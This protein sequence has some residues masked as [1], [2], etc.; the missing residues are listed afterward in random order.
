MTQAEQAMLTAASG[1]TGKLQERLND[2]IAT[3][4]STMIGAG[5]PV[6]TSPSVPD[7]FRND[8]MAYAVYE[9][10]LDFPLN[11]QIS[12]LFLTDAR[13]DAYKAAKDI[14]DKIA[15]LKAGAIEAPTGYATTGNW[16]SENRIIMRTHPI[17]PPQ[18]QFTNVFNNQP[19]YANPN[20]TSITPADTIPDVPKNCTATPGNTAGTITVTF[21]LPM[22]SIT[23][24]VYRGTSA[25]TS[26]MTL[27]SAQNNNLQYNDTGLVTGETYFY[28][29]TATN[30]QGTSGYSNI[31]YAVAP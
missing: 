6:G 21:V 14:L 4:Y 2:A 5:Y 11:S 16:G 1:S 24:N 23:I 7:R 13:K 31:A 18:S 3:F 26:N 8:I 20:A 29:V 25:N 10:L 15:N 30:E 22:N 28:A 17:P 12:K 27:L 19:E 9:W